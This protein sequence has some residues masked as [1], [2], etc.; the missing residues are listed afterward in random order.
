MINND[1]LTLMSLEER[2]EFLK[3]SNCENF[4]IF[5]DCCDADKDDCA[6]GIKKWLESEAEE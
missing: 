6:E 2:T 4:C 3:P 1:K 5:G